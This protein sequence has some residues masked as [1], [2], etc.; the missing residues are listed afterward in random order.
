MMDWG[1]VVEWSGGG[2]SV[3]GRKWEHMTES[4]CPSFLSLNMSSLGAVSW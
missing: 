1:S 4:L 3:E 2:M